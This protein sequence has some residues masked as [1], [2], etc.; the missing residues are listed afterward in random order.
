METYVEFGQCSGCEQPAKRGASGAWW[1][2]GP[3]C[4]EPFVLQPGVT[5]VPTNQ[6][7]KPETEPAPREQEPARQQGQAPAD[8]QVRTPR[9]NR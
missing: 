1:H 9:S 4:W 7:P 8:R 2:V 5:F 6:V 3:S